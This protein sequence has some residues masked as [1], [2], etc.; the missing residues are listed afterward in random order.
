[1]DTPG[2]ASFAEVSRSGPDPSTKPLFSW[3]K[4]SESQFLQLK[5]PAWNNQVNIYSVTG[6]LNPRVLSLTLDITSQSSVLDAWSFY[7]VDI[8]GWTHP[9]YHLFAYILM[10]SMPLAQNASQTLDSSIQPPAEHLYL[11]VP[12]IM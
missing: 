7:C 3:D 4:L 6:V 1:M 10:I 11:V 8:L 2:P 9:L 5:V 12:E